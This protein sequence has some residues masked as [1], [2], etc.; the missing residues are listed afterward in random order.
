[1]VGYN[2]NR[3]ID[4]GTRLEGFCTSLLVS[5]SKR[6]SSFYKIIMDFDETRGIER[7]VFS[8]LMIMVLLSERNAFKFSDKTCKFIIENSVIHKLNRSLYLQSDFKNRMKRETDAMEEWKIMAIE[9]IGKGNFYNVI[10]ILMVKYDKD[11][12]YM[13]Q[14]HDKI[15]YLT[16]RTSIFSKNTFISFG[17]IEN[18]CNNYTD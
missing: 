8:V 6:T 13:M 12:E 11:L 14:E 10:A 15:D 2:R 9:E 18:A 17:D 5:N 7:D 4:I 1:M 16:R 3:L